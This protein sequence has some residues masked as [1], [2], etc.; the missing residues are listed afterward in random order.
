MATNVAKSRREL[1]LGRRIPRAA[2]RHHQ[3]YEP[4]RAPAHGVVLER[5]EAPRERGG[6]DDIAASPAPVSPAPSGAD[7]VCA[8]PGRC[9]VAR[10]GLGPRGACAAAGA[11][12]TCSSTDPDH[13][14]DPGEPRAKG[15]SARRIPAAL[16]VALYAR[17]STTCQV[18]AQTMTSESGSG[19][20][21][22]GDERYAGRRPHPRMHR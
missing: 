13:R 17:G 14:G 7:A 6:P 5:H 18:E 11:Q 19:S 22:T 20:A 4:E 10:G 12:G 8:K 16:P 9:A 2:R 1:P 15:G 21:G 3:R